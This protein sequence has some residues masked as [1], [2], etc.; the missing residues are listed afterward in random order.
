MAISSTQILARENRRSTFVAHPMPRVTLPDEARHGRR[1]AT[2]RPLPVAAKAGLIVY[3]AGVGAVLGWGA[4]FV[5]PDSGDLLAIVA[6]FAVL[7]AV[8]VLAACRVIR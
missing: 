8:S 7:A 6:V 3:L 2:V 4:A 5:A 1:R